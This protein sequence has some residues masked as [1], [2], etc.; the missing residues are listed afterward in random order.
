MNKVKLT[1]ISLLVVWSLPYD[2]VAS[3]NMADNIYNAI[4]KDPVSGEDS[5]TI[6]LDAIRTQI[7]ISM[8]R[9]TLLEDINYHG[10]EGAVLASA[11]SRW[12][13]EAL[14]LSNL[15]ILTELLVD[16]GIQIDDVDDF[17]ITPLFYAC[18]YGQMALVAYLI[19]HGADINRAVNTDNNTDGLF[20]TLNNQNNH[21]ARF[22]IEHGADSNKR[23][24]NGRTPLWWACFNGDVPLIESLLKRNAEID[25]VDGDGEHIIDALIDDAEDE[26]GNVN[27]EAFVG[28]PLLIRYGKLLLD[29]DINHAIMH[30]IYGMLGVIEALHFATFYTSKS[31]AIC[32]YLKRVDNQFVLFDQYY[33]LCN[34]G[35]MDIADVQRLILEKR[36]YEIKKQEPNELNNVVSPSAVLPLQTLCVL[37]IINSKNKELSSSIKS[38]SVFIQ[39][40][41][42]AEKRRALE[43]AKKEIQEEIVVE[44][45]TLSDEENDYDNDRLIKKR[46]QEEEK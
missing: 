4:L 16:N 34:L 23:D 39:E 10:F 7:V 26:E 45:H 17:G 27:N 19:E 32:E 8:S 14:D 43:D 9:N 18:Y 3:D 21:I 36:R 40:K 25:F 42:D 37:K 15:L 31:N 5:D 35:T 12:C 2:M 24:H 29:R 6:D 20:W 38:R 28:I 13:G 30:K 44:K 41:K 22:L 1:I 11:Y 33:S 46:K